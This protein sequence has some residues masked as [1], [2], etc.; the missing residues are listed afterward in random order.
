[1]DIYADEISKIIETFNIN[2]NSE[3][4]RSHIQNFVK[5]FINDFLASLNI[6]NRYFAVEY[7]FKTF[8]LL[9]N[10]KTDITNIF[11]EIE[12]SLAR[13]FTVNFFYNSTKLNI[14]VFWT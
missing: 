11:K 5:N 3:A 2:D 1:M 4:K 13:K 9:E 14:T 8:N 12:T 7:D 10:V 6:E